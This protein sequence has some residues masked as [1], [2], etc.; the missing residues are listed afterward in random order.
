VQTEAR[1]HKPN[2]PGAH[3]LRSRP[4]HCTTWMVRRSR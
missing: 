2:F 3:L 4:I 1:N